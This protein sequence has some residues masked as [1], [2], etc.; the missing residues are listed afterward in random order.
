MDA[1]ETPARQIPG[2]PK[3]AA[4]I[5]ETTFQR[6]LAEATFADAWVLP[7]GSSD[8]DSLAVADLKLVVPLD[9]PWKGSI[10]I[11]ASEETARDLAAGFHSLP[12]AMVDRALALEFLAEL[13]EM[14]ARDLFC[15]SDIPVETRQ[16]FE[17]R[18]ESA[19][20]MWAQAGESRTFL[21]CN[22]TGRILAAM[23][24]HTE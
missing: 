21:G 2:V 1:P 7:S 15:A 8:A 12:D 17:P 14:L 10:L 6:I 13:A 19:S 3:E 23:I 24:A 20:T 5:L 16:P 4:A 18:Q 22:G 9:T 11:G